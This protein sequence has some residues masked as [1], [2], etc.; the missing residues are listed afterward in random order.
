MPDAA[1]A[2]LEEAR[3]SFPGNVVQ[4]SP[5]SQL[6]RSR[7]KDAVR[8]GFTLVEVLIAASILAVAAL[9]ALE[10][11]SRSDSDSLYARRLALASVEA[12]RLLA[13]S[14]SL[15][16]EQQTA[17]RSEKLDGTVAAEALGGCTAFVRE[18]R[19]N[20]SV[21]DRSGASMRVPVV[22]L[23]AEIVDPSGNSLVSLERVVPTGTAE[24][25]R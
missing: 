17:T 1:F 3:A 25:A 18:Y 11:L 16:K 13:E 4:G 21:T 5:A 14:A 22:R 15:V 8:R 23:T 9:A 20:L 7:E 6:Q 2:P 12:E 24:N 10:L 19:E